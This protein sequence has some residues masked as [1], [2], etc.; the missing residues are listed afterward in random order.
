[1][2]SRTTRRT[3]QP[4]SASVPPVATVAAKAP[5]DR[6]QVVVMVAPINKAQTTVGVWRRGVAT[7]VVIASPDQVQ[8]REQDDPEQVDHVP[9]DRGTL[10]PGHRGRLGR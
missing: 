3:F 1:M 8:Q 2:K 7:S 9:E 5:L 6:I 10:E 4:A